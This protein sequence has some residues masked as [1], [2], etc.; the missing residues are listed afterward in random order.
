[1]EQLTSLTPEQV[2]EVIRIGQTCESLL[3]FFAICL[4]LVAVY[5]LFR[6]FF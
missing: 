5:K 3:W 2:T 6:M 4:I 1:M